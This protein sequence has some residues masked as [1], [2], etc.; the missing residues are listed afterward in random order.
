MIHA[1][2]VWLWGIVAEMEYHLYPWKTDGNPPEWAVSR[3]NL[4]NGA[5]HTEYDE[6][7]NFEWLKHHEDKI[8]KLQLEML[9]VVKRLNKMENPDV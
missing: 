4:D 5:H 9:D 1:V 3:Y 7:L 2:R 6:H 8:A